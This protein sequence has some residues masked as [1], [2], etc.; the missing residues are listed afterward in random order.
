MAP[1]L[2]PCSSCCVNHVKRLS[3]KRFIARSPRNPSYC[4]RSHENVAPP[5]KFN[6][7]NYRKLSLKLILQTFFK[8]GFNFKKTASQAETELAKLALINHLQ[9]ITFCFMIYTIS[10]NRLCPII[11]GFL[12]QEHPSNIRNDVMVVSIYMLEAWFLA[13]ILITILE[14]VHIPSSF[15]SCHGSLVNVV[16]YRCTT[17]IFLGMKI[18]RSPFFVWGLCFCTYF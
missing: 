6:I 10:S 2:V 1:V 8:S 9:L 18:S 11:C 4:S 17:E 15:I 13:L 7:N 14:I 5:Y 3:K 12:I 16:H